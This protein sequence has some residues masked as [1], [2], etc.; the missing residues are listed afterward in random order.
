[1]SFINDITK[2]VGKIGKVVKESYGPLSALETRYSE[3]VFRYPSE[4]GD[5]KR[6][7]HTVE[8][9]TWKPIQVPITQVGVAKSTGEAA[10]S[11]WDKVTGAAG[12]ALR[13]VKEGTGELQKAAQDLQN[14]TGIGVKSIP[15]LP[16]GT[17]P[18][19]AGMRV[20]QNQQ[21]NDRLFDWTRR[22]ERGVLIALYMPSGGWQ[23][24]ISN[25]YTQQ[26]MTAAMGTAGAILDVG[27][28]IMKEYDNG[29]NGKKGSGQQAMD[30]IA[31]PIAV[32]ALSSLAGKIPGG[33]DAGILR[34]AGLNALGYAINPQFEML[35]AG[36]DLRE[37]QFE[38]IMTPRSY[39]E[40]M[41]IKRI[42]RKFKYHASPEYLSGQGRYIVPPSYFDITFKF[43][44]AESDWL[45]KISTCVLKSMDV[46]YFGALDQWST[47][48]D[49]SPIQ[50]KI[51]LV[52]TELEMMH[53]KLRGMGY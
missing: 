41:L 19:Y 4:V 43:N 28:S 7:P 52:F 51:Q 26:S 21:Y 5:P 50:T 15:T 47:H 38:F 33:M 23:D 49:G 3:T 16:D 36:T 31:G 27:S 11:V 44:G 40:A 9:Q 48:A 34:D 13:K 46:D 8:F 6:Y 1:M 35:Y 32:E 2:T 10:G 42:I 20:N 24:R 25:Q 37:F 12:D 14:Q 30:M 29:T 53:K 18:D 22:A 45:P 17:L 39:D